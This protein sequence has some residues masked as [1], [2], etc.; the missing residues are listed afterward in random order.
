MND[1]AIAA[2]FFIIAAIAVIS[3]LQI[4][5]AVF[6]P[7]AGA[8]FI[9]A[10]VW[11]FQNKLQRVLPRLLALALVVGL[12]ICVFVA[13]T[14]IAAWGFGRIG[15]S[16]V[17]DGARFQ[18]LYGQMAEW[19]EGHG[20]VIAGV[21][22]EHF[23]VGWLLRMLQG[24]TSRLNTTISFWV[25]VII[26]V[27]LGLLDTQAV[28][29]NLRQALATE[30]SDAIIHGGNLT[31]AKLRRYM[32]VRTIMSI[33][34]GTLVWA[35]SAAFG[36]RF[37]A[38]WGVIAFTLNYIPFM[39]PFVATLLPSAYALAQ[40]GSPEAAILIFAG[41][42]V[43]QFI[44]GSYIEPR[45]AGYALAMSP[46]LVLFSVFFWSYVWGVFGAFI[47]VPIMITVLTFCGQFSS[48]RW[49][50]EIC[51]ALEEPQAE[52]LPG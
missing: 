7:V 45:V 10:L 30:T 51:G 48:T 13:L 21:W 52:Q 12:I 43:I 46:V 6:A 9:I 47:G 49:I 28:S 25:V 40:F 4:A 15:R 34:T 1:R 32:L 41:L 22:A 19:L 14:S 26:Y 5:A 31:A 27:L 18:A 39:G 44:I 2:M 29:V 50:A 17:A 24:V 23:N 37:A 16:V 36:L 8:L 3:A 38:E 35:L 20:I 33:A 42:N 11:P